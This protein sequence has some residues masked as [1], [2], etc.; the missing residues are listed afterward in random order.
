[1]GA[2]KFCTKPI[3]DIPNTAMYL[4]IVNTGTYLYKHENGYNNFVQRGN[5]LG[6]EGVM[7]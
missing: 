3:L 1:M 2:L 5:L 6:Y 7:I 4:S